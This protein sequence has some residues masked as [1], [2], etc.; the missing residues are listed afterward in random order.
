M[1]R[2]PMDEV[3]GMKEKMLYISIIAL[4]TF[5]VIK[6]AFTPHPIILWILWKLK[7]SMPTRFSG[8]ISV[9]PIAAEHEA[10]L[11]SWNTTTN[12]SFNIAFLIWYDSGQKVFEKMA[13]RSE[14]ALRCM[15]ALVRVQHHMIGLTRFLPSI[16]CYICNCMWGKCTY[17]FLVF[18]GYPQVLWVQLSFFVFNI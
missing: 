18:P 6:C 5:I 13:R 9:G 10:S 8:F 17:V 3:D 7:L 11:P 15:L 12:T 16:F 14:N 2:I 1:V 4:I